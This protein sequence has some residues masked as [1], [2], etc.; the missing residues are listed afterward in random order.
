MKKLLLFI[1]IFM[2]TGITN[3]QINLTGVVKD[4][5]GEPLEM[6]SILAINKETNKMASYGFTDAKRHA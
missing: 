4:S 3:A 6:A 1:A 5:I 2:V